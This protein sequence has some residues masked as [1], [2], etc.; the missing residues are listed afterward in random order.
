MIAVVIAVVTEAGAAIAVAGVAAEVA[1][2][3]ASRD[4]AQAGGA[5]VADVDG[6]DVCMFA[7]LAAEGATDGDAGIEMVTAVAAGGVSA[8]DGPRVAEAAASNVADPQGT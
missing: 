6:H 1:A 5:A 2:A 7:A 3:G 8:S 4:A